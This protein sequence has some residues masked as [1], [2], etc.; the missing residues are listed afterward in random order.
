MTKKILIAVVAI[1]VAGFVVKLLWPSD[2]ELKM[3][4]KAIGEG[5]VEITVTATGYVQPVDKVEIGTQ[6]SGVVQKI[7]VD[8]NSVVKKGQLIAELDKSTL[9]ERLSQA[10][11]NLVSAESA[12]RHAEQTYN[13]TKELFE[14]KAA[15]KVAFEDAENQY[16]Q[17]KTALNNAKT[18]VREAQVNLSYAEIYSPINGVVLD[19]AVEEGQT[20]AASFSTPTLFTIA[21]D[22][23]NM[24]VE[25][26]IDEADIGK[27]KIGQKVTFT[28]DAYNG[29][30]F[31]GV[32]DQIRL[33]PTVTNNVV[34]YTVIVK[35]P[36]PDEKLFPGMTASISIVTQSEKGVLIPLEA[37][38]FEPTEEVFE[39]LDKPE[40]PK[41]GERLK[42]KHPEPGKC[43]WLKK[44]NSIVL[45]SVELGIDDGVFAVVK[46][47]VGI[48]DSVVV[49]AMVGE[50]EK[51][52][53][54]SNPLMP[55]R[56]R[57]R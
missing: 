57:K 55:Q 3:T 41:D 6:V 40:R 48:G 38:N 1:A 36:N 24:Q 25:A 53:S 5:T 21:N 28:V 22:L 14:L 30:C 10:N 51:L 27:V 4:S 26:D 52:K 8:Y 37:L 23:K 49:S 54:G 32:V 45:H 11:S 15:T 16:T 19:R 35:A 2:K 47:G 33:Q 43:A 17:A 7:Y 20:V 42:G 46:S 9:R 44:G 12:M 29:E 18:N 13:R 56:K 31:T 50:K 39:C 34:T